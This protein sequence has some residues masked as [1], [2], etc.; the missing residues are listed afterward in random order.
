MFLVPNSQIHGVPKMKN[1]IN[2][3]KIQ[4]SKNQMGGNEES[5]QKEM[6]TKF[7]ANQKIFRKDIGIPQWLHKNIRVPRFNQNVK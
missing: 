3:E 6:C 2:N 4:I 7:G 5:R 1:A